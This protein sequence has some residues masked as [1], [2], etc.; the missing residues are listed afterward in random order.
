MRYL[1]PILTVLPSLLSAASLD[2]ALA[3]KKEQRLPEAEAAFSAVLAA[4]PENLRALSERATVRGWQQRY[5]EAIADWKAVLA[6]EP[7]QVDAHVGLARVLSWSGQRQAALA[8]L[9]RALLLSARDASIWELKGDIARADG[10][11][12]LALTAYRE[13]DRLDPQDRVSD[14]LGRIDA[15]PT[16]WRVDLGGISD[17]YTAVRSN[18]VSGYANLGYAHHPERAGGPAWTAGGGVVV[19]RRFDATDVGL[20]A[21]TTAAVTDHLRLG[22]RGGYVSD[23]DFM[24]DW[25]VGGSLELRPVRPFALLFDVDHNEYKDSG[26]QVVQVAPGA[27]LTVWRVT[28]ELRYRGSVDHVQGV[29]G[30]GDAVMGRLSADFG[31]IRPSLAYL[32]GREPDPPFPIANVQAVWGSV[33]FPVDQTLSLRVDAAFEHRENAAGGNLYDRTSLGGGLILRF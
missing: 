22:I 9:D 13:A 1:L 24:P 8:E 5:P 12:T 16:S 25:K 6:R 11:R 10:N 26:R 29:T 32:Q 27:A 19:E 14:R 30:K 15:P 2:E 33:E 18:E 31:R 7:N 4:E 20:Q 23:A 17:R 21:E 3:L 28:A